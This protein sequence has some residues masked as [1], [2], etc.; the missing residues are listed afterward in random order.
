M[1]LLKVSMGHTYS[2]FVLENGPGFRNLKTGEEHYLVEQKKQHQLDVEA[3][4][5]SNTHRH[6][7]KRHCAI[8]E[9]LN[10]YPDYPPDVLHDLL[11]GIVLV[12]LALC[13][14]ML[15]KK[16]YFSLEELNSI[17]NQFPYEWKYRTNCPQGDQPLPSV[18]PLV[19]MQL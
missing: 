16:K 10:H 2:D 13:L 7:V 11:D 19:V 8:T 1:G 17:I 15:I 18:K 3:A 6:G 12:E 9:R 5:A 14:D 4:L